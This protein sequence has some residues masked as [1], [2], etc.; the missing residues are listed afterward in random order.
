MKVILLKDVKGLG[1]LGEIKNV[2][3][4]YARNFLIKNKLALEAT[5]SNIKYVKSQL[6]ALQKK[7]ERKFENAKELKEVIES[8]NVV[9]KAKAGE[10]GKLFGSITSEDI[11]LALKEQHN[12]EID[13]KIIETEPIKLVGEYIVD[14]RLGM[15]VI[16]KLKV[17]I[18]SDCP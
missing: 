10:S 13:K 15:N 2:A 17:K 3:D 18:E 11:A 16:A 7:N 12:L 8:L 9:I 6:D 1:K 4:G 5:E 14:V